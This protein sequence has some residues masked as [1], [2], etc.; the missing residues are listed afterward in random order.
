MLLRFVGR[1]SRTARARDGLKTAAGIF[2]CF[3]SFGTCALQFNSKSLT[4][5]TLGNKLN[6][7]VGAADKPGFC[8]YSSRNLLSAQCFNL[9]SIYIP[10]G[11]TVASEARKFRNFLQNRV[12][13]AGKTRTSLRTGTRTIP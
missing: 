6:T 9:A 4:D 11:L 5:V 8:K 1:F 10:Q 13:T 3:D 12:L 7:Y 2:K